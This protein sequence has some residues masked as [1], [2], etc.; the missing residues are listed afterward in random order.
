MYKKIEHSFAVTV[1]ELKPYCKDSDFPIPNI[2]KKIFLGNG[3]AEF[4]NS[5]RK[6]EAGFHKTKKSNKTQ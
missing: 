4:L 5:K 6:A 3:K 2:F 1:K